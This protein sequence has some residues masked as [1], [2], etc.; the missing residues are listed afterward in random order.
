MAEA[1]QKSIIQEGIEIG[2]SEGE[3]IGE[4]KNSIRNILA[5]LRTKFSPIPDE[6]IGELYKRTD[7]TALESLLILASQCKTLDEFANGLK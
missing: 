2:R 5:L 1:V 4:L 6:I 7:L 3:A